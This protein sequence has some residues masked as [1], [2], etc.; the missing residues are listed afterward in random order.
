MEKIIKKNIK[1]L[2]KYC[3]KFRKKKKK[4]KINKKQDYKKITHN[5]S[6]NLNEKEKEN[7]RKLS[8]FKMAKHSS[9]KKPK[10]FL[11]VINKRKPLKLKTIIDDDGKKL[12]IQLHKMKISK[13]IKTDENDNNLCVNDIKKI[14]KK[15][16]QL[17]M[18]LVMMK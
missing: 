10:H 15:L 8:N 9:S 13:S 3:Y 7:E 1:I 16:I 11:S 6:K 18:K 14:K 12:V 17:I 5:T 2:R 4:N